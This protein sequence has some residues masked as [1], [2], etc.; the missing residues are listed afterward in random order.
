M[1]LPHS[2]PSRVWGRT[3]VLGELEQRCLDGR[4]AV[5]SKLPSE[6]ELTEEFSVSR[7]VIREAL[8]GLVERGLI[9]IFPGRGSFVRETTTS[10]LAQPLSR[11]ARRGGATARD[12]VAARLMIENSATELATTR[13]DAGALKRMQQA[14]AEHDR[15]HS[16]VEKART[17]LAFHESIVAAAGNPLIVVMFGSIRSYVFALMLRSHSDRSIQ[18]LGDPIHQ[19]ILAA[20]EAGDPEAARAAM[21]EHLRLALNVY[22]DDLDLPLEAMLQDLG[23][24]PAT[25]L[26]TD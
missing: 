18:Q 1:D 17:D 8:S 20:I 12:L 26:L 19:V 16:V 14:L 22:G 13:R 24:D 7:P 23:F 10:E 2:S 3:E 6:R 11:V 21:A 25:I 4:Y 5:G 15:S 9:E